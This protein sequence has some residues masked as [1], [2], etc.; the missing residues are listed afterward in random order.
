MTKWNARTRYRLPSLDG[1]ATFEAAARVLSFTRAADELF[2]TQSAV[3]K[4]VK[5]LEDQLGV[6]LFERRPRAL[7]LTEAGQQFRQ[8]A[9]EAL[10]R[11]Q[12]TVDQLQRGSS[13][14]T[15]IGVTM[16]TIFAAMWL[17]PRLDRFTARYPD[18]DVRISAT[19][20]LVD[21]ARDRLDLAIRICAPHMVPPGSPRLFHADVIAVCSPRVL[22]DPARPLTGPKDITHHTLLRC[23]LPELRGSFMDWSTWLTALGL[24]DLKP[25]ATVTFNQAD[26]A[27]QAA[28]AGQGI[29][30]AQSRVV[31]EMINSGALAA[32]FGSGVPG[33]RAFFVVRAPVRDTS[34]IRAA[35]LAAFIGW[36]IEEARSNVFDG[37]ELLAI[38]SNSS[39]LQGKRRAKRPK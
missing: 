31:A 19:T 9:V 36:L 33:D 22:R 4:Q 7:V 37:R 11:L 27:I 13:R 3:S 2:I 25:A 39:G 12:A 38:S 35:A 23:D 32:P 6:S 24:G 5:Q 29:A 17:I 16:T 26:Q 21:L 28:A 10:D 14:G 15:E 1:L 18:V 34:P 8:G 20:T 30:L